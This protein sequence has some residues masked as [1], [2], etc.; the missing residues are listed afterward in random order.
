[1]SFNVGDRIS[2]ATGP[3]RCGRITTIAPPVGGFRFYTVLWDNGE[4]EMKS[5][6]ELKPELVVATAWDLMAGNR[7]SNHADFSIAT[8]VHKVKNTSANTI[9]TLKAS[10]TL[11]KPYQF[12]PLVKFLRSDTR[13]ILVADE[14]GLGKTIEAGHIL[15]ELAARGQLRNALVICKKSLRDKW[16]TEMQEKFN[17]GFRSYDGKGLVDA[18]RQD[19]SSGRRTIMAVINYETCRNKHLEHLMATSGYHFDLVVCDE[20]HTIR[21][22]QSGIH[23]GARLFIDQAAGT[24]L[25]TA[26]PMMTGLGNLH[27][28]IKVLDPVRFD[29]VDLFNNAISQNKPLIKA[30]NRLQANDAPQEIASE[31][32]EADV[33]I[34]STV[35]DEVFQKRVTTIADLFAGDP[36]YQRVH[37]DLSSGSLTIDKRVRVQQDLMDLNAINHLFTRTR[38]RDVFTAN[39]FIKRAPHTLRIELSEPEQAIYASVVDRYEDENP[40]AAMQKKRQVASCLV[41]YHAQEADLNDGR[42][43]RHIPDSKYAAFRAIVEQVVVQQGKKLVVFAFFRK[44]LLYLA[45]KLK[46]DGITSE[47]IHGQI[48]DRSARLSRFQHQPEVQVLLSSEVGSE[49]LDLQFCDALVNYDLPWNPMVVEQRI[50]RIDRVG[51]RS[52]VIN[53]YNLVIKGTIEERIHDRLYQ[54]INLFKHS[55]GALEDILGEDEDLSKVVQVGIDSLYRT[56]LTPEEQDSCLEQVAR[57]IEN[58]RHILQM[59]RNELSDSFANDLHFQQ[60]IAAIEQNNRYLTSTEIIHL[61]RAFLRIKLPTHV[62]RDTERSIGYIDIPNAAGDELFNL[63]EYYKDPPNENPE[64][65]LIYRKFKTLHWGERRVYVTFDQEH[66]FNDKRV[67]FISAFHPIV[68]AAANFFT[69]EGLVRNQTHKIAIQQDRLRGGQ[70]VP[71]GFHLL[72]IYSITIIK[73]FGEGVN[74]EFKHIRS[75]LTDLNGDEPKRLD[76]ELS[77]RVLA[78][79]QLHGLPMA[80]DL[81]TDAEL[82]ALLQPSIMMDMWQKEQEMKREEE[83]KFLSQMNRR[84]ADKMELLSNRIDRLKAQIQNKEGIMATNLVKLREFEH[85]KESA[86]R[87]KEAAQLLSAH[88]LISLNLI[89]IR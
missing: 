13:R 72:A 51:Q 6:H 2:S 20:A 23:K 43:P 64:L 10:R 63:I 61:I 88:S 67:E 22:A 4:N 26:T 16:R 53:I 27:S 9:S 50:G 36:L 14:V 25:L 48:E 83:L 85:E 87:K 24:V 21:N 57:A 75:C 42:Y 39:E 86:R 69:K 59:V 30:L 82:V 19:E 31:L 56:K 12:K 78:G 1:M 89:E 54:R 38:K 45:A 52:E 15:L 11:F 73:S 84:T 49:G 28:L 7:W 46:E 58:N 55:I 66:A 18:I 34:E 32:H 65:E 5:E 68:N 41:S 71:I 76:D 17:L 35:N 40:M 3:Y 80:M 8:T 81:A 29:H 47:L 77:E 60:E 79:L 74:Q 37:Q 44:T 62:L 33:V 70:D